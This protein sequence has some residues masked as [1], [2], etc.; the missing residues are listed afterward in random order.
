[1]TLST[2]IVIRTLFTKKR[3]IIVLDRTLGKIEVVP[4]IDTI[5]TGSIL[6]YVLS[7]FGALFYIQDIQVIDVPLDAARSDLSFVHQVLELCYFCLPFNQVADGIYQSIDELYMLLPLHNTD[8]FKLAFLVK[9]LHLLGIHPRD[10]GQEPLCLYA[11]G[12]ESIDTI[13]STMRETLTRKMIVRWVQESM[14]HHP[15][16]RHFKV[17]I[18][19][20]NM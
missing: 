11:L 3:K 4:S 12:R 15:L 7:S 18:I 10:G 17:D 13:M 14:I 1:M 19:K 5:M 9:L 6:S 8:D 2:G 20:F 16:Y